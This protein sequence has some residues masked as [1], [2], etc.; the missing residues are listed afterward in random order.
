MV[1]ID[2]DTLDFYE[3]LRSERIA[4]LM[5]DYCLP[6]NWIEQFVTAYPDFNNLEGVRRLETW[7]KAAWDK[8][9][10]PEAEITSKAEALF[11]PRQQTQLFEQRQSELTPC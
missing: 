2:R 10:D 7:Y 4:R 9:K 6:T 11:Y 8:T 5:C 1:T 3:V